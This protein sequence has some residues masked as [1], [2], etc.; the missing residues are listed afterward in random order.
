LVLSRFARLDLDSDGVLDTTEFRSMV[1]TVGIFL[2]EPEL[3]RLRKVF[4][5]AGDGT[6]GPQEF[7]QVVTARGSEPRRR[8]AI[9]VGEASQALRNYV[10]QCQRAPLRGNKRREPSGV[11]GDADGDVDSESAWGDLARKHRGGVGG[12]PFP[13]WLDLSDVAQA[14]E[15]LGFRL[16]QPET[17]MLLMRVSPDGG[18]RVTR[19]DFHNFAAEPKPRPIGELVALVAGGGEDPLLW[20]PVEG[21]R[22]A[23]GAGGGGGGGGGELATLEAR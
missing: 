5:P 23:G 21:D 10:L 11:V 12:R 22:R 3:A 20:G 1:Q 19:E 6:V 13:G 2:T 9:R 15:R 17:R 14:V 18:G 4:D 8:Q 7:A 16:S